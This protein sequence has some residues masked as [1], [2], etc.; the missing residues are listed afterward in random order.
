MYQ[1]MLVKANLWQFE[2]GKSMLGVV[3]S[4]LRE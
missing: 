1:I 4:E 2:V 3:F